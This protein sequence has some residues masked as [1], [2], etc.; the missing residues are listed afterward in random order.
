MKSMLRGKFIAH[1]ALIKNLERPYMSNLT[2]H[3]N[4]L[5]QREAN[6]CKRNRHQEIVKL[7]AEINQIETKRTRSQKNQELVL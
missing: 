1:S 6:K 7:R 3:M 4:A 2:I 5:N